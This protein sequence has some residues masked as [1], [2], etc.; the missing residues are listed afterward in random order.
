MWPQSKSLSP[1]AI[2]LD[3]FCHH[4]PIAWVLLVLWCHVG[5]RGHVFVH[6]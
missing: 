3:S 5:E 1:T 6:K 4:L 2:E